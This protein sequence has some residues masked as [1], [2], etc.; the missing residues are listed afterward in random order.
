MIREI[1]ALQDRYSPDATYPAV[2]ED[3]ET[4]KLYIVGK[5]EVPTQVIRRIGVGDIVVEIDRELLLRAL[6]L[7]ASHRNTE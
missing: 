5:Y 3:T 4:G 1:T 2:F 6:R 7:D